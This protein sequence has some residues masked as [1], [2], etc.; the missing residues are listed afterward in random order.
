[1]HPVPL[2]L[3]LSELPNG[4]SLCLTRKYHNYSHFPI[5]HPLSPPSFPFKQP[6]QLKTNVTL[7]R[8]SWEE[9]IMLTSLIHMHVPERQRALYLVSVKASQALSPE[10]LP[11]LVHPGNE[12]QNLP[13]NHLWIAANFKQPDIFYCCSLDCTSRCQDT[14][15]TG[16]HRDRDKTKTVFVAEKSQQNRKSS[17]FL[18]SHLLLH[19]R[20][21][22]IFLQQGIF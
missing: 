20:K 2:V 17:L 10:W 9:E 1:M 19:K 15:K 14:I 11:H 4:K 6:L 3:L 7:H 12:P 21:S 18:K 8:A 13:L 16:R 5:F 22:N